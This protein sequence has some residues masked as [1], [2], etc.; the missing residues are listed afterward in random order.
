MEN[1][2]NE[3]AYIAIEDHRDTITDQDLMVACKKLL[4][5][6]LNSGPL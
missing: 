3:S 6:K 4:D 5:E 2:S 1:I